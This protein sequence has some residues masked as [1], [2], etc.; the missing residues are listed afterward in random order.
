MIVVNVIIDST[1]ADVAALRQA[2]AEMEK[3]SRAEPGCEDY[4]FSVELNDPTRLRVTERWRDAESLRAHFLTPHMAA[5]NA[6]MA[7]RAPRGAVVKCYE[8]REI[9]LPR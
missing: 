4:T 5:F 1:E 6:A 8:V 2:I 9:P 7:K 3:A